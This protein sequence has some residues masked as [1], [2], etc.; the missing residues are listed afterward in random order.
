MEYVVV[1]FALIVI[2]QLQIFLSIYLTYTVVI[3]KQIAS[4][5]STASIVYCSISV[6]AWGAGSLVNSFSVAARE[7]GSPVN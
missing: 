7:A 6:A 1:I 4:T 2:G 5:T 3:T